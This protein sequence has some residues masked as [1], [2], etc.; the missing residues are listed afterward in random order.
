MD[1]EVKARSLISKAIEAEKCLNSVEIREKMKGRILINCD[2]YMH[3][4]RT[5]CSLVSEINQVANY[6]GKG[7]DDLDHRILC[8]TEGILRK[9]TKEQSKAVRLLAENIRSSFMNIRVLLR[10]Y[11]KNIET[12][13]PQL[14]NNSDLVEALVDYEKCWEKGLA[15]FVDP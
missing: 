12:V 14:K 3:L 10:K 1:I 2:D 15:Y 9:V 4:R 8:E 11:E 6:Y 13:D 5:L 7:R